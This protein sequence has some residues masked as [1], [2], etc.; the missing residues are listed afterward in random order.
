M[1]LRI[2][3]GCKKLKTLNLNLCK[4]VSPLS[5]EQLKNLMWL[6]DLDL[7]STNVDG[8]VIQC[9]VEKCQ[10]LKT[11]ELDNCKDIPTIALQELGNW[12]N[13]E[14][15]SLGATKNVNDCVIISLAKSC[16]NLKALFICPQIRSSVTDR[17]IKTLVTKCQ[18]LEDLRIYQTNI[19]LDTLIVAAQQKNHCHN[20]VVLT[21]TIDNSELSGSFNS[22]KIR[23]PFL[24]VK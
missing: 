21:I 13:L 19:S 17:S 14:N 6:E 15:L 24:Q 2:T 16:K 3:K 18:F 20:N 12:K 22:L 8:S 11:L 10:Q 5:L 7:G 23:S 4:N 9:I 1:I